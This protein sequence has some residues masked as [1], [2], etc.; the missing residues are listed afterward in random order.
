MRL[1]LVALLLLGCIP[2]AKAVPPVTAPPYAQAFADAWC[3]RD[4][5][6]V[7]AHVGGQL[8]APVWAIEAYFESIGRCSV[9]RFV[10]DPGHNLFIL[11]EDEAE[12]PYLFTFDEQGR[13]VGLH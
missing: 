11:T 4:S 1:L 3:A 13:C 7:A 10:P 9:A 12:V 6:Y 8:I 5:S 2:V